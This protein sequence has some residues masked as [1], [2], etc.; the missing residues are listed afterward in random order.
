MSMARKRPLSLSIWIE[1]SQGN[2]D[3]RSATRCATGGGGGGA[4]AYDVRSGLTTERGGEDD[5]GFSTSGT[6]LSG[7]TA[8]SFPSSPSRLGFLF[9]LLGVL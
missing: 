1:T 7:N 8:S 4:V 6:I 5:V 3:V 9:L 2:H